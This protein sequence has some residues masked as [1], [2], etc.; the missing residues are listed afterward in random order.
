MAIP[1]M[2]RSSKLVTSQEDL[3]FLFNTSPHDTISM[4][5]IMEC[6][7]DFNNHRRFNPY[8]IITVPPN[9]YGPEGHKNTNSFTTTVGSFVFNR[10]FI[11]EELIPVL[12]Y[13]NE[14]VTKKM[15]GKL[16]QKLSYALLEDKI[17]LDALKHF[18]LK[19]QKLQGMVDI[20]SPSFTPAM[21]G[22]STTIEAKRKE[23]IKKY[24]QGIKD[25]DPIEI[26]KFSEELTD[27]ACDLIKDDPS[28]DQINSGAKA[29]KGNNFAK[30]WICNGAYKKTDPNSGDYGTYDVI[31]GNF[32]DGVSAD[33]YAKLS[34]SMVGGPYARAKRTEVGGAWEKM[35]VRAFQYLTVLPEN[36]DCGTKRY[37]KL[38]LT[39]K[40]IKDWMYSY[41]VEGNNLVELTS[42]NMDKY[43]GKTVNIRYSA[44]CESEK[45]IC[46][47]CAGNLF[48]RLGIKNIGVATYAI[49]STLKLKSM[50][51]FH[52]SS[53]KI[54]K[55][56][57]YGYSKIFGL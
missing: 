56:K 14:P 55:M 2:K 19:T 15:F 39:D 35:F 16:N 54:K 45:G 50:K 57:D 12:G 28:M 44:L 34:D 41:I 5:F 53:L 7:G 22:I 17:E 21:M 24:E 52:D 23:L 37:L 49:A 1:I 42:D 18:L 27:Y 6:F 4:S 33:E 30:M 47:H 38:T 40:N 8:D 26:Q 48:H 13:V 31:L 20:L 36:S 11:E 10:A 3:D 46:H 43:K 25:R 32:M 9:T 29:S 51:A